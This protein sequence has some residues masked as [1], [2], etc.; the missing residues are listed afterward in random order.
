MDWEG[1]K[2][3]HWHRERCGKSEEAHSLMKEDLAGGK[4]PAG[5]FGENA[6]WWWIMILSMNLNS[7]M[8]RLALSKSWVA[9][10]MKAI[11]FSLINIPGHIVEH[12][13]DFIIRLVKDHPA[14][15]LLIAARSRI[16]AL[17]WAPSG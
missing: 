6:A 9:K 5:D 11:R 10:R 3:I 1:E 4:L 2:L 7:V 8:K 16:M 15:D 14:I 13:R 17:S 12:S